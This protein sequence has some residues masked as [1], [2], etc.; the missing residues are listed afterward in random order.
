[1]QALWGMARVVSAESSRPKSVG[2]IDL[3]PCEPD[4][5]RDANAIAAELKAGCGQEASWRQRERFVPRLE[6]THRLSQGGAWAARRDASYVLT[7]G[8]GGLGMC[9]ANRMANEGGAQRLVL[10]GRSASRSDALQVCKEY[11]EEEEVSV[12]T[13]TRS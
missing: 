9:L 2:L 8:F 7:G 5:A 1:M 11:T 10:C 13:Q 6:R 12:I 4:M 3:C